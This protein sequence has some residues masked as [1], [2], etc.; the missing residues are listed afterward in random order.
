MEGT[1][2]TDPE[3]SDRA[4]KL[5]K[6]REYNCIAQ[7]EFRRRRKERLIKLGASQSITVAAQ[8]KEIDHLRTQNGELRVE[9]ETLKSQLHG[10]SCCFHNNMALLPVVPPTGHDTPF[11]AFSASSILKSMTSDG[12]IMDVPVTPNMP[13]VIQPA[14]ASAMLPGARQSPSNM[15]GMQYS[16]AHSA[17][18]PHGLA[19]GV[20][21]SAV[22]SGSSSLFPGPDNDSSFVPW[23]EFGPWVSI[24]GVS[25]RGEVND[26]KRAV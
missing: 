20:D 7:R 16:V 6:K 3:E 8:A 13:P 5:R 9:N 22:A 24:A 23:E 26:D 14:L 21:F 10:S 15:Y 2:K 17:G 11:I 1:S 18:S 12:S 19:G 25:M 4:S